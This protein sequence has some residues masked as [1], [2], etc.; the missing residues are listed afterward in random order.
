MNRLTL[1]SL[2]WTCYNG[3]VFNFLHLDLF[4]PINIDS[5]LIGFNADKNFL[6][7]DIFWITIKIFDKT[8]VQRN[9]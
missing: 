1:I 2:E 8:G 9:K 5:S 6:F 7:I 4:K 3:L